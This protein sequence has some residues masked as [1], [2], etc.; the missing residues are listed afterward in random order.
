MAMRPL[1]VDVI[2]PHV[3]EAA[4]EVTVVQWLKRLGDQVEPGEP[5]VEV[6]IEKA[7]ITIDAYVTG[8]LVEILASEGA[9]VVPHDVVARIKVTQ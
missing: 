8:T 1:V 5:L 7:T 6:D 9:E 3:G 4:G 2:V